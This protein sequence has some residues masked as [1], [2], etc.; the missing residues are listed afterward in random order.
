[1]SQGPEDDLKE[2]AIQILEDRSFLHDLASPIFILGHVIR[3]LDEQ[4]AGGL[5]HQNLEIGKL[6]DRGLRAIRQIEEL[7]AEHRERVHDRQS[8]IENKKTG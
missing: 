7:H 2:K 8:Q 6:I 3:K 1:M 4:S 5:L